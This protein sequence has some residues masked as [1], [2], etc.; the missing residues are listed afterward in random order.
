MNASKKV[1]S[2]FENKT[3]E[4]TA[5][6]KKA[7]FKSSQIASYLLDNSSSDESTTTTKAKEETKSIKI[8]EP[9]NKNPF[10]EKPKKAVKLGSICLGLRS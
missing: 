4:Q 3:M 1:F 10:C 6:K 8:I 7:L 2:I 5:T 9:F